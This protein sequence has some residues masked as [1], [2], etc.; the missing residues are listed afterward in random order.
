MTD[1]VT[2]TGD[3]KTMWLVTLPEIITNNSTRQEENLV[4][5]LSRE[6]S[7]GP[8]SDHFPDGLYRVSCIMTLYLADTE[9]TK[10]Q[11]F[12]ANYWPLLSSL[13]L[14]TEEFRLEERLRGHGLGTW[15][16]Q[17]F[18]L[19]ARGLPPETRVWPIDISKADEKSEENQIRRDRLWHAMGFRFPAGQNCSM[20]L[21][22]D[23]LQLPRG[24]CST[25]R[26]EPLA[27][28][29]RRLEEGYRGLQ[30]K[31]LQLE[32]E[33][34]SKKQLIGSI[35]K[36]PFLHLLHR[37]WRQ[38]PDG[39][40]DALPLRAEKLSL[41]QSGDSDLELE[42]PAT[43]VIRLATL[44]AQ[45]Q[46]RILELERD[47][48]SQSEE[49]A[50]LQAHPFSDMLEKIDNQSWFWVGVLAFLGFIYWMLGA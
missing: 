16:T 25:L 20:P 14:F 38:L 33:I 8:T 36:H 32:G 28:G 29:V 15:I 31:I 37:K 49:L 45:S 17:Q 1:C 24:R 41:P 42:Q 4:V 35:K 7:W 11:T 6:E 12:T 23:E 13:H 30:E 10:T 18:V 48:A 39:K 50:D 5:I 19:W 26:V 40:C 43:G 46:K 34:L 27:S 2:R 9:Q 21:R 22:A 44:C 3:D 47:L